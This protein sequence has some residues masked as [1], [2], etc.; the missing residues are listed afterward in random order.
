[1]ATVKWVKDREHLALVDLMLHRTPDLVVRDQGDFIELERRPGLEVSRED[2]E[3]AWLGLPLRE[4]QA[5]WRTLGANRCGHVAYGE[6]WMAVS[7]GFREGVR[8][9]MLLRFPDVATRDRAVAWVGRAGYP[10]LT[11]FI[12]AAVEFF[13][14]WLEEGAGDA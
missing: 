13:E 14:D 12:L 6:G 8:P 1:M 5:A 2:F 11:A 4:R 3:L 7:D 10:T 9:A